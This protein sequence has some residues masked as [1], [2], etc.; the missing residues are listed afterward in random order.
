MWSTQ[1]TTTAL[2]LLFTNMSPSHSSRCLSVCKLQTVHI[3]FRRLREVL[4]VRETGLIGRLHGL[5]QE[6]LK[7]LAA[8]RDQIG[9]LGREMWSNHE[10]LLFSTTY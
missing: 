2:I 5:T 7:D 1:N 9:C 6:K 4:N 8:Q 10:V 3:T